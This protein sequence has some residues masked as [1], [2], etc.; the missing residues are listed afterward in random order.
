MELGP[1]LASVSSLFQHSGEPLDDGLL[2]MLARSPQGL[3]ETSISARRAFKPLAI[4]NV[5]LTTSTQ[6]WTQFS[7]SKVG[8]YMWNAF[9]SSETDTGSFAKPVMPKSRRSKGK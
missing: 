3:G 8:M 9:S 5:M 2:S 6:L 1:Y 7:D 4:Q